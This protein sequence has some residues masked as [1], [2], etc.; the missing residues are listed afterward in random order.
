VLE[1]EITYLAFP[2]PADSIV[3]W[4]AGYT[5]GL[6]GSIPWLAK[7][8]VRYWGD[9]DTHGFSILNRLRHH[10]PGAGSFLMDRGTLLAHRDRWGT[11]P[12]PTSAHLDRLTPAESDLYKDLVEGT[13]GPN[14]R[15]EQE[16]IGWPAVEAAIPSRG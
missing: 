16:R 8:K 14:V 13:F 1:N 15:L 5:V 2:V 11:E 7:K 12:Q 3:L 10:S 6:A 9:P 4:G